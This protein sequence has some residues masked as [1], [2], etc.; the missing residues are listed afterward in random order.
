LS[1]PEINNI[2]KIVQQKMNCLDSSFDLVVAFDLDLAVAVLAVAVV[3][4]LFHYSSLKKQNSLFLFFFQSVIFV[5]S[6]AS[7]HSHETL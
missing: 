4:P 7:L 3:V 6:I 2:K 1:N 5:C